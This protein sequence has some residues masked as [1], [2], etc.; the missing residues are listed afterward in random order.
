MCMSDLST[1]M[2][3]HCVYAWWL[4]R[5]E[6]KEARADHKS[7]CWELN[8]GSSTEAARD[9]NCWAISP[10][11][12]VTTLFLCKN[13]TRRHRG[14]AQE[15][16]W[17]HDFECCTMCLTLLLFLP[18]NVY[19]PLVL[20]EQQFHIL[21]ASIRRKGL[22]FFVSSPFCLEDKFSSS[23]PSLHSVK[24]WAHEHINIHPR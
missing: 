19:N 8:P 23:P 21:R 5:P 16:P 15:K 9:L 3:L 17:V 13:F 18:A 22:L 20:T 12:N 1:C 6:G 4:Q 14:E 11:Q 24:K 10:N 2:F 7:A